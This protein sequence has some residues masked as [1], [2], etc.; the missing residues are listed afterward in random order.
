[1]SAAG[2]HDG[3]TLFDPKIKFRR[4]RAWRRLAAA[5]RDSPERKVTCVRPAVLPVNSCGR[6]HTAAIH[7]LKQAAARPGQSVVSSRVG[8]PT[9]AASAADPLL[10]RLR[11]AKIRAGIEK[12]VEGVDKSIAWPALPKAIR[13]MPELNHKLRERAD[14]MRL[15]PRSKERVREVR[16]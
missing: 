16:G 3:A 6:R 7:P 11:A 13:R 1:M 10:A 8:P 2:G 4:T 15:R 14:R 9:S 12:I 5:A